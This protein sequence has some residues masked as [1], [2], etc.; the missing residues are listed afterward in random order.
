MQ[1][2]VLDTNVLV[3]ALIQYSYP[4]LI[5]HELFLEDKIKLCFSDSLMSEYYEV[6]NRKKFCK[7]PDFYVRAQ[8]MLADIE[9]NSIHFTPQFKVNIISDKDDNKLLELAKA[10]KANFIITGNTNDF[11]M[12][13]FGKTKI[14]SPKEYWKSFKN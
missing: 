9:L 13:K 10:A 3:T 7:F 8:S 14:V 12:Q 2:I 1:K 5:V 6:L 4:H 11:T